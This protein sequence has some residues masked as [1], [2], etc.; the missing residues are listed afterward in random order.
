MKKITFILLLILLSTAVWGRRNPFPDKIDYVNVIGKDCS[1]YFHAAAPG[2][3]DVRQGDL[4]K[5]RISFS[6]RRQIT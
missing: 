5:G 2:N 1:A 4:G 6:G 3:L